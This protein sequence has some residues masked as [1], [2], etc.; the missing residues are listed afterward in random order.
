MSLYTYI[1]VKRDFKNILWTTEGSTFAV[2]QYLTR[3]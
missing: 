1:L 3:A 2:K